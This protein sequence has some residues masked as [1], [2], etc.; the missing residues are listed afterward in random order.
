MPLYRLKYTTNLTS[1]VYNRFPSQQQQLHRILETR[2][3]A[4]IQG[5]S[6][7]FACVQKGEAPMLS[8]LRELAKSSWL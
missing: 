5:F 7:P 6:S 8:L 2:L 3:A 1:L 4:R